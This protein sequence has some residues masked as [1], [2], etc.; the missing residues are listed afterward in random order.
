MIAQGFFSGDVSYFFTQKKLGPDVL[1]EKERA[2]ALEYGVKRLADFSTGRYCLRESTRQFGFEGDV[3]I[4]DRGMPLLPDH[5]AASVSHSKNL[6]G[7]IAGHKDQYLSLGLDIETCDRV[8]K[9]M[10]RL[11]F[12][13]YEIDFLNGLD[14]EQQRLLSTV[15][16]SLKEAFYKLQFP[17]TGIYLDFP[18]VEI[19]GVDNGYHIKALK[20]L[21]IIFPGGREVRGNMYRYNNEIV[22]YCSLSAK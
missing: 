5:I 8:H 12:T 16:F 4:G 1:S 17:L 14:E 2:V 21:G 10:W 19:Y 20:P 18:E 6:C 3:L 15:F 13:K 9:G 22:T 11:L 7:A